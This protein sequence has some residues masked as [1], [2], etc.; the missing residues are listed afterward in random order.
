MISRNLFTQLFG[1]RVAGVR[2]TL[3]LV[4]C[5]LALAIQPAPAAHAATITV[6]TLT[7]ENDGSCSDEDCSLRDAIQ[8]AAAGDT[9]NFS[10]TDTITLVLGQLTIDKNLTIT[11]PGADWL[12][13]S[14]GSAVRVLMVN[15]GVTLNLQDLTLANGMDANGAGVSNT[16]TLNVAN[17][18]LSGNTAMGGSGGISTGGGIYSIGAVTIIGSTFSG[19]SARG[20]PGTRGGGIYNN[21]GTLSVTDSTFSDNITDGDGGAIENVDGA[22]TITNSTFSNNR[23]SYGGAIL[24]GYVSG[25]APVTVT[26]STFSGNIATGGGTNNGGAIWSSIDSMIV[27]NSTF[28]NNSATGNGS[29]NY[30]GGGTLTLRNSI[31]AFSAASPNCGGT[32]TDGGGNLAWEDA[33]CP[34][35]VANPKFNTLANNGGSTQTMKLDSDSPSIDMA[36]AANC[37]SADQRGENRDDLNCDIG[38]FEVTMNDSNWVQRTVSASALSTFGPARAGIQYSGADPGQTTITKATTWPS[39]PSNA[40]GVWWN[41]APTTGSGLN[42]TLALCYSTTELRGLTEG[43]LLFWRFSS[44]SWSQVG[45]APTFSGTSPNRCAQITGVTDLS[46]WTLATG[47]PGS[48]PTAVTLQSFS[49]RCIPDR[50][51]RVKWTTGTELQVIGFNVWRMKGGGEWRKMN[52]R[53]IAAKHPGGVFGAKYAFTDKRVKAEHTYRYKLEVVKSD[54]TSEWS[55]VARVKVP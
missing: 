22:A 20:V 35:I 38:A 48:P 54:G 44:G 49:A 14:G 23:A 5:V 37:P 40:L 7:D 1:A 8:V 21:G 6:N 30:R 11:G 50:G 41:I 4:L 15:A 31:V 25:T 27:T 39:Q 46:G 51:V 17:S 47:N 53:M 33:S 2:V 32:I 19:N 52:H 13:I 29:A 43:D 3:A 55:R 45:S 28:Y 16:G 36:I 24:A 42:L 12:T 26:N 18:V 9:I 34:G 10:V